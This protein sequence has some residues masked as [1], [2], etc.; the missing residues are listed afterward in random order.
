MKI[1]EKHKQKWVK[2][3]SPVDTEIAELIQ[4]LSAFSKLQTLESCQ[5][6]SRGRAF[7]CFRYGDYWNHDWR[8]LIHFVFDFLGPRLIKE[9]ADDIDLSIRIN[10]S[11]EIFAELIIKKDA[12]I[13]TIKILKRLH[14]NF[15]D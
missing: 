5:N 10:T 13:K 11:R 12:L 4:T 7:V 6:F 8:D 2:V 1:K 15:K 14:Q 9:L 3:N